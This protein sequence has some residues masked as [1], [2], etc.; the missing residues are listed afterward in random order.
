VDELRAL[1][2][3]RGRGALHGLVLP[4]LSRAPAVRRRLLTVYVMRFRRS[5]G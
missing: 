4:L 1:R 3:P 2:L 5:A